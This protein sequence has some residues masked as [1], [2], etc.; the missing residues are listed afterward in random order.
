MGLP[1]TESNSVV[2]YAYE[3]RV[4]GRK[5][6]TV[7]NFNPS[8][9][10]ALERIREIA[11]SNVDTIEIVPGRTDHQLQVERIETHVASMI[12]ALGYEPLNIADLNGS[13]Q[14]IEVL[15]RPDGTRRRIVYDR[16]WVNTHSKTINVGTVNVTESATLWPTTIIILPN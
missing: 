3:F 11:Y 14:I 9:T 12:D 6:G 5:V 16:C 13:I 15:H 1:P 7:Q 10:R 8:S 4:N 2:H